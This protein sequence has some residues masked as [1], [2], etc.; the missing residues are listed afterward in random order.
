MKKVALSA[1]DLYIAG[2]RLVLI[3]KPGEPLSLLGKT[4]QAVF[5]KD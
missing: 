4:K 1:P 3:D 2:E 5:E